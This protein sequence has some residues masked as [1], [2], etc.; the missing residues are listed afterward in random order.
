MFGNFDEEARKI[1]VNAKKEMSELKHPY[2]GSEHLLLAI[3]NSKNSISKKL[4]EY[5]LTY[6]SFK[7][8]LIDVVGIGNIESTNFLYTPLLKRIIENSIEDSKENNDGIVTIEHLFS[9]LLE[10]GEG[11]AIRILLSMNISL[12]DLYNEFYF[13]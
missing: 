9:A 7:E 13:S 2:V 10:E 8:E 1:L 3:L 11:V 12:D 6:D 5:K 4:G